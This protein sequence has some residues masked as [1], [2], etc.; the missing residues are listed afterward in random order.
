MPPR[1]ADLVVGHANQVMA[2]MIAERTGVR[3]AVLSLFPM[4]VPTTRGL[5]G[6]PIPQLPGPL[7]RAG[8]VAAMGIFTLGS[9]ALFS[10]RAFNTF[11]AALVRPAARLLPDLRVRLRPVPRT[12]SARNL[13]TAR[14]TG[15]PTRNSAASA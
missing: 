2:P 3:W 6:T 8:N 10:D 14:R 9:R 11:R 7:R 13:L 15:R 5:P 4:L 1:A 12:G